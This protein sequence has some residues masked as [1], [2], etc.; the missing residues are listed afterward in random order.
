[1]SFWYF[2]SWNVGVMQLIILTMENNIYGLVNLWSRRVHV[3]LLEEWLQLNHLQL[4]TKRFLVKHTFI[5][6]IITKIFNQK[7]LTIKIPLWKYQYMYFYHLKLPVLPFNWLPNIDFSNIMIS[8]YKNLHVRANIKSELF[9][10]INFK[11]QKTVKIK[12][13]NQL[14]GIISSKRSDI[15]TAEY[16]WLLRLLISRYS[17]M[18]WMLNGVLGLSTPCRSWHFLNMLL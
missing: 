11:L 16:K 4:R 14:P 3:T 18:S 13:Q 2:Q 12:L 8:K 15:T 5:T 10:N 9:I 6:C 17:I 7:Y 1:M